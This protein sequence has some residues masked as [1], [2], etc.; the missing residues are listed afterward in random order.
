MIKQAY[1]DWL[2]IRIGSPCK[3]RY[4]HAPILVRLYPKTRGSTELRNIQNGST[5][6]D[7]A[8]PCVLHIRGKIFAVGFDQVIDEMPDL[9]Q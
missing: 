6:A 1:F 2:D 3:S 8:S 7:P 5:M 9:I 4:V